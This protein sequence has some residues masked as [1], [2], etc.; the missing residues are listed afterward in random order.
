MDIT[1]ELDTIY[2][3]RQKEK[4]GNKEKKPPVTGS[5]FSRPPQGSS[6]KRTHHKK[7]KKGK[8]FQVSKDKL[9][10]ALLNKDNKLVGSEKERRIKEGLC[11]YFGGKNPI[12]TCFKKPQNKPGSSRGLPS[13][14]GKAWVGI[15]MCSMWVAYLPSFASFYWDFLIIDSPKGEDLILGDYFLYHFNLI[16]YCRNGLI[17]YYS[18]HKDYSGINSFTSNG[19]DT[20]VNNFSLVGELGTPSLPS[21][22]HIPS[23]IPSQSLLQ[24]RNEFFKEIKDFGEAFAISS[25]HLF[26]GDMNL[27]RL[28]FHAFLEDQWDEGEDPEEI[29]GSPTFLSLILEFILH[30]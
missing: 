17:N 4:V 30:G 29:E 5:N 15:M 16:I 24:S 14:Q 13:K 8:K 6:L 26:Q 21:S 2:H 28:S 7:N 12:E 18:N 27:P 22:V 11:T 20:S 19:L 9:H 25:L 10:A 3:E 23:I 1:L